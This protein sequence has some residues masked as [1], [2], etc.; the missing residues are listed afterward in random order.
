[1]FSLQSSLIYIVGNSTRLVKGVTHKPFNLTGNCGRQTRRDG[2][3]DNRTDRNDNSKVDRNQTFDFSSLTYKVNTFFD[4]AQSFS[5]IYHVGYNLRLQVAI[6]FVFFA[7]FFPAA[8]IFIWSSCKLRTKHAS[9]CRK[10]ICNK[11]YE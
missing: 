9:E 10:P 1:L 11:D 6:C 4:N 7:S 8:S 5:W 3:K 2:Q